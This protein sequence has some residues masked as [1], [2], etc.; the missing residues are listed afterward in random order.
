MSGTDLAI[1]AIIIVLIAIIVLKMTVFKG[2]K[3]LRDQQKT[4][5]AKKRERAHEAASAK[6]QNRG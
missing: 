6:E 5:Q 3:W 4:E 1:V 2:P